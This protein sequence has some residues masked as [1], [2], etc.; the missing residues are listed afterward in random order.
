MQQVSKHT[1]FNK[2]LN[3]FLRGFVEEKLKN[4]LRCSVDKLVGPSWSAF[5]AAR[6]RFFIVEFVLCPLL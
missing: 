1:N 5:F 6:S 4:L 3:A 2:C